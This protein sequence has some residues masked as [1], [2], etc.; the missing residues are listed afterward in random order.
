MTQQMGVPCYRCQEDIITQKSLI[1]GE[2]KSEIYPFHYKCFEQERWDPR[3]PIKGN[4]INLH[5]PED[6][7]GLYR[8][9]FGPAVVVFAA[10]S[11]ISLFNIQGIYNGT[12]FGFLAGTLIFGW[13]F[14]HYYRRTKLLRKLREESWDHFGS[15]LK[16]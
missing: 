9:L 5:D 3:S 7:P 16:A 2:A 11:I 1:V 10:L 15:R 6:P 12:F 14:R 8:F 4:L 13:A